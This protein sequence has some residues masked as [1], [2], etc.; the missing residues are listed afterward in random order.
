MNNKP[1]IIVLIVLIVILLGVAGGGFYLYTTGFFNRESTQTDT[2]QTK[3]DANITTEMIEYQASIEDISINIT[4][5]DGENQ[6]LHTS[7]QVFGSMKNIQ[8]LVE[9][10]KAE[11]IDAMITQIADR[12]S[13]EL[14]TL[15]GQNIL[16][17]DIIEKINTIILKDTSIKPG[18]SISKI[19][20]TRLSIK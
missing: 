1:I 20:F 16:K 14:L 5:A 7:I 3:K 13:E 6:V 2:N 8:T 4:N 15:E 9:T 17:E 11:I 12:S 19:H 18:T 10:H